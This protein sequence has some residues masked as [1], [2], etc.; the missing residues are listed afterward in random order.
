MITTKQLQELIDKETNIDKILQAIPSTTLID[1]LDSL[2]SSS[3]LSKA[4]IINNSTLQRNYAYQIID[5]TKQPGRDK[6]IMLAL[7]LNTTQQHTNN[8]LSLSNNGSL[9]PK[10]ER[11]ALII[12]ALNNH[13]SVMETNNLLFDY[14]KDILK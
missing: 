1:Y 2:I 12:I 5:G 10:V 3:N 8:L 9:Y 13:Y 7:A 6:V 11:D 4:Q 14:H